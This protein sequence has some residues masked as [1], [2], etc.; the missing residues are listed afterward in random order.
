MQTRFPCLCPEWLEWDVRDLECGGAETSF[1]Q[2]NNHDHDDHAN[3]DREAFTQRPDEVTD[4]NSTFEM[5]EAMRSGYVSSDF[6]AASVAEEALL[7]LCPSL[8]SPQSRDKQTVPTLFD[9]TGSSATR[10]QS[11]L[12]D[13][14]LL[15]G[16]ELRRERGR[17][18]ARKTRF[19]LKMKQHQLAQRTDQLLRANLQLRAEFQSLHAYLVQLRRQVYRALVHKLRTCTAASTA[20]NLEMYQSND[21]NLPLL[22]S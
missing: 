19:F 21:M 11:L 12:H 16:I 3:L 6:E 14:W 10:L 20:S 15:K 22:W 9:N 5:D 8:S 1:L 17:I 7:S 4:E 18:H 13:Q 2:A